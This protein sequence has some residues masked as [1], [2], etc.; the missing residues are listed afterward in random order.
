ME[1]VAF[2]MKQILD[3]YAS[4]GLEAKSLRLVGGASKS[5]LWTE[6]ISNVTG[7][8]I[9]RFKEPNIACIG[10]AALAGKGCGMFQTLEEASAGMCDTTQY[11]A[12]EGALRD[13]YRAK[14]EQYLKKLEF[15][16]KVY[17]I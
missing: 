16:E 5:P 13:Y 9:T 4:N 10:A 17:Q 3:G 12:P 14:N 11:P 8:P 1:G 2:E 7:L 6:I 15:I